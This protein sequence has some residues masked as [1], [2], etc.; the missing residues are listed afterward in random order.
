[1][2]WGLT[3]RACDSGGFSSLIPRI[4][5][6]CFTR[7][8]KTRKFGIFFISTI[9][10]SNTKI[11]FISSTEHSRCSQRSYTREPILHRLRGIASLLFH[12][13]SKVRIDYYFAIQCLSSPQLC[14]FRC[15]WSIL[16]YF[17]NE[18]KI[19]ISWG[20]C[21]RVLDEACRLWGA[22]RRSWVQYFFNG[23]VEEIR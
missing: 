18:K 16:L 15:Q 22:F 17:W 8:F 6:Y 1:M 20:W 14:W 13:Y 5:V 7:N 19:I 12:G 4:V 11:E 2:L 9:F 3:Y 21:E 23:N 10:P